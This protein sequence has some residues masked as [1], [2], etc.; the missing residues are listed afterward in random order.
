M[1]AMLSK[2]ICL[3]KGHKRGKLIRNMPPHEGLP[4]EKGYRCPRCGA[5]WA[6]K[7]KA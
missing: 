2:L 3:I 1:T 5:T 6:R 7:V 4:G